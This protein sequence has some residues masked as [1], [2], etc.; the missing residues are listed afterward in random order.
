MDF[1]EFV[2]EDFDSLNNTIVV[3]GDLSP[4]PF[5]ELIDASDE[6]RR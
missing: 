1:G 2:V 3:A 5:D 4:L 6:E